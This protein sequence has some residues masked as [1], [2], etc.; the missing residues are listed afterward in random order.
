MTILKAKSDRRHQR[1]LQSKSE[2][3]NTH[4]HAYVPTYAK[5]ETDLFVCMWV[6]C[7]GARAQVWPTVLMY[8]YVM[9][10]YAT[11]NVFV[12]WYLYLCINVWRQSWLVLP[13]QHT[14]RLTHTKAKYSTVLYAIIYLCLYLRLCLCWC[15]FTLRFGENRWNS[16]RC[17]YLGARISYSHSEYSLFACHFNHKGTMSLH[18][19]VAKSDTGAHTCTYT[20]LISHLCV[21]K[22]AYI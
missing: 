8:I 16:M 14:H 2:H 10:R 5:S 13:N 6:V 15:L 9:C 20:E 12:H 18:T 3:I 21:C 17:I 19:R 11:A 7:I 1:K 22:H 4:I